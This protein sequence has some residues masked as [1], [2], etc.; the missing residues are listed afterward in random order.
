MLIFPAL[1]SRARPAES[2]HGPLV[3]REMRWDI[4]LINENLDSYSGGNFDGRFTGSGM[5]CSFIDVIDS[6]SD[7]EVTQKKVNLR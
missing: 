7:C 2:A 3:F 6:V 5:L 4:R 1:D